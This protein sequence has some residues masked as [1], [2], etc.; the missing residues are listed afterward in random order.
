MR[1]L[2]R[3]QEL[4]PVILSAAPLCV[5]DDYSAPRLKEMIDFYFDEGFNG[6][7]LIRLKPLGFARK[8]ELKFGLRVLWKLTWGAWSTF[9][10]KIKRRDAPFRNTWFPLSSPRY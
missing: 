2:R 10:T 6:V 9:L 8:G 3:V 4:F 7:G 5:I 1:R